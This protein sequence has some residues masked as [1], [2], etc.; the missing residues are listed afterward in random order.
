MGIGGILFQGLRLLLRRWL[1]I[2]LVGVLTT[3]LMGGLSLGP[4]WVADNTGLNNWA[5]AITGMLLYLLGA[6]YL[7]AF[8]IR[9]V[10]LDLRGV[11]VGLRQILRSISQVTITK[12]FG[13]SLLVIFT[14]ILG[15]VALIIPG[16]VLIIY[17]L[18]VPAVVVEENIGYRAAMKRSY[19]LVKGNWWYIL[20][21]FLLASIAAQVL[22]QIVARLLG[23]FVVSLGLDAEIGL[24]MLILIGYLL[25]FPLQFVIPPILYYE[26]RVRKGEV[27]LKRGKLVE[28]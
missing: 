11:Q 1:V 23:L 26:L 19:Q 22:V 5:L 12:L 24:P 2:L 21:S 20:G 15:F 4:Y 28:L 16:F 3:I 27:N 6:A 13:T 7:Y 18:F 14:I 10:T 25:L 17:F 9:L 8:M